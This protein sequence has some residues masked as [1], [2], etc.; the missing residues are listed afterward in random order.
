VAVAAAGLTLRALALALVFVAGAVAVAARHSSRLASRSRVGAE[1]EARVR[2]TLS[3][4]CPRGLN[5]RHGV[6]WQR[7]GNLDHVLLAPSGVGLVIETKT[8]RYTQDMCSQPRAARWLMRRRRRCRRGVVPVLSVARARG[9]DHIQNG[10][11]IVSPDRMLHARCRRLLRRRRRTSGATASR[12]GGQPPGIMRQPAASARAAEG[13]PAPAA[14]TRRS[15]PSP[16]PKT[17]AAA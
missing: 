11:L 4:T 17:R 5:V 7:Q 8:L 12:V 14:S 3:S 1:S 13:D 2:H 10:V 15:S 9:L 16:R 6:N